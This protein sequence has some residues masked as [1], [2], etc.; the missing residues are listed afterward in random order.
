MEWSDVEDRPSLAM[1]REAEREG[2]LNLR[3]NFREVD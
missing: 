1:T 2:M 3:H